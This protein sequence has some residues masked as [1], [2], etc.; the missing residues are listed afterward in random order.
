MNT[1]TPEPEVL[2]DQDENREYY[3]NG[4]TQD[5]KPVRRY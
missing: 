2:E 5:G 1:R 3:A 4:A